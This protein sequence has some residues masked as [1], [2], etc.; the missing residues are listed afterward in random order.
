MKNV[1]IS[2][3]DRLLKAGRDYAHR[4]HTS[5][6]NLIRKSLRNIVSDR[7]P[8]WID[9]CL[10]LMDTCAVNVKG[11]KWRREELYDV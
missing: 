7:S 6:N 5:L 1:T 9:E 3:D 8:L 11:K 4:Q 10:S 2:I